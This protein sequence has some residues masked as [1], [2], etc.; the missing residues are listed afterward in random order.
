MGMEPIPFQGYE[1]AIAYL[2]SLL[3][4][5][6]LV[7]WFGS[8]LGGLPFLASAILSGL[9]FSHL[10][11][12]V[13]RVLGSVEKISEGLNS[14]ASLLERV[15]AE[16]FE[17]DPLKQLRTKLETEG[18]P[19][20]EAIRKLAKWVKKLEDGNRNV[21]LFPFARLMFWSTHLAMSI[22]SWRERNGESVLWMDRDSGRVRNAFES[23]R[24]CLFE[25]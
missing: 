20:S 5:I 2:L 14:Y 8:S 1:K 12:R 9:Y 7:I 11:G 21:I 4:G 22:E 25:P 15:E 6:T 23:G 3:S 18:T 24:T 19:A 13:L 16:T 10:G 17:C